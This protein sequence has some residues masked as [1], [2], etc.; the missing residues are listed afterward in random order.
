M[1]ACQYAMLPVYVL[2]SIFSASAGKVRPLQSCRSSK[3]F[4]PDSVVC[5]GIADVG[6]RRWY[7]FVRSRAARPM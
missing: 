5:G 6:E 7:S 2:G 1:Q 3:T 4:W